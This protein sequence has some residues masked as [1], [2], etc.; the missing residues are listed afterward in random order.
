M[1]NENKK[2]C[3]EYVKKNGMTL[4]TRI[5]DMPCYFLSPKV[6]LLYED[7]DGNPCL[8]EAV[9]KK[10]NQWKPAYFERVADGAVM[11]NCIAYRE[12]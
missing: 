11:V 5:S 6:T 9:Y 8:C 3:R 7:M 1:T 4:I 2:K 12:D 10:D